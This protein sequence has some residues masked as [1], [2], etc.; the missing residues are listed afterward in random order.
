[1]NLNITWE[2]PDGLGVNYRV[3]Y[4]P[5]PSEEEFVN[6]STTIH[7]N[8]V[9]IP[10]LPNNFYEVRVYTI[11]TDGPTGFITKVGGRPPCPIPLYAN[12]Q[13][14]ADNPD[15][16]KIRINFTYNNPIVKVRV[17]RTTDNIVVREEDVATLGFVDFTLPKS[18]TVHQTYKIEIANECGDVDSA[19]ADMGDYTVQKISEGFSISYESTC[20]CS[21]STATITFTNTS[22]FEQFINPE[23]LPVGFYDLTVQLASQTCAS[24]KI[25]TLLV[26]LFSNEAIL[27]SF[28][29]SRVPAPPFYRFVFTGI[30]FQTGSGLGTHL[31]DVDI[32]FSCE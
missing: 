18:G 7:D 20:E 3:D 4:R 30:D 11:C 32:K 27:P 14:T 17:T 8:F 19:Y 5:Y 21:A 13:V 15:S 9:V 16:Q 22:T 6:F 1:M 28:E 29:K 2:G 23:F 25:G 26:S 31:T 24:N 10:D 12:Y